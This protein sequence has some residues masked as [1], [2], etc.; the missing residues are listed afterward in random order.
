M[1]DQFYYR[2][3]LLNGH[4]K[5]VATRLCFDPL[6]LGHD[7]ATIVP[8]LAITFDHLGDVWPAV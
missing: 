5:V 3:P 2:Q 6:A 7:L 8:G 4:G 1:H